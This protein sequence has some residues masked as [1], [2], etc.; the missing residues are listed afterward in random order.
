LLISASGVI[1]G[2]G[3]GQS[4]PE[5][6][7]FDMKVFSITAS[8]QV[9][10]LTSEQEVPAGEAV[11]ASA[12]QLAALVQEWP[13]ARL[14]EVWNQLPGAKQIRKFT[15]SKSA[16][17]RLWQA[18]QGLVVKAGQQRRKAPPDQP[19]YEFVIKDRKVRR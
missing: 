7:I 10:V 13:T 12:E 11:F 1:H 8:N 6:T 17:R 15:D 4:A 19:K 16:V 18:V 9:R 2:D 5:G 14:V 3:A